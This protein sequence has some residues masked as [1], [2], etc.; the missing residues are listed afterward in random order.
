MTVVAFS[1]PVSRQRSRWF[2]SAGTVLALHVCALVLA[3]IGIQDEVVLEEPEGS[4]MLELAPLPLSQAMDALDIPPGP[5]VETAE[6]MTPKELEP[7]PMEDELP[8]VEASPLAPAPEIE[9]PLLRPV[10]KPAESKE[11]DPE[12]P[13]LDDPAP[14]QEMVIPQLT[15]PPPT[16]AMMPAP[17]TAAQKQGT[18]TNVARQQSSWQKQ[19]LTQ[20]GKHRRYPQE[21]RDRRH[22]GEAVVKFTVDR[23]GRVTS[24]AIVQSSGSS[25]L[26]AEALAVLDRAAPLPQPPEE[27]AGESFPLELP[28]RFRIKGQ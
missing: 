17:E 3:I 16:V 19:I 10:E 27:L 14:A 23:Q 18:T 12:T 6:L 1:D 20:L 21:A 24:K 11:P 22:Q 9:L 4:V 5:V 26:D 25:H 15:A 28:I 7:V 2:G 8:E 13:T